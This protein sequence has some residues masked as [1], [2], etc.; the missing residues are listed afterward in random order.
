VEGTIMRGFVIAEEAH[1]VNVLPPK[2]ITGGAAG[3]PFH[4]REHGHAT[5][6]VQIGASAAAPTAILVNACSSAAGA[7]AQAIPF[8]YYEE[9][10][11]GGDTLSGRLS[12][13]AAGIAPT[14]NDNVMYV[15]ELDAAEL[16]EG[17][18]YVQLQVTAGA[19]DID[20]SAIAV[21]SGA[22]YGGPVCTTVIT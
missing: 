21:L 7:D 10:T 12:A 5:I 19:S 4:L 18:P 9:T 13:T 8:A 3:Q 14:G 15:I 1:V 6:A 20:A 11:S 22:R 16:P 2:N 17:K